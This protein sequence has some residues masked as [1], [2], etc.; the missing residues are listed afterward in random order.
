MVLS[1][2]QWVDPDLFLDIYNPSDGQTMS[3]TFH[4]Y[5]G[6]YLILFFY[7]A[8]FT[9]VCPTELKDLNISEESIISY[10]TDI[11]VVST[12]TVYTHKCWVETEKLL[13]WFHIPMV[14]D[15]RWHLIKYFGVLNE[16][17]WN[18]ERATF[19]ISPAWIIQ[20]VDIVTEAIGRSSVELIRRLKALHFVGSHP[21]HACPSSRNEWDKTLQPHISFSWKVAEQLG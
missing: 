21:G 19:I 17:T 20:S 8:D 6:K 4:D 5:R 16:Q 3:K 11:L 7:P 18:S 12:D 9:F 14:S 10:N 2:E 13:E 15:R 1:I